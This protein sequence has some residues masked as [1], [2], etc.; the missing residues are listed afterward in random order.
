[1]FSLQET[2]LPRYACTSQNI[3]SRSNLLLG[4][5]ALPQTPTAPKL[6]PVYTQDGQLRLPAGSEI[7]MV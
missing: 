2:V 5:V 1:M 4:W 3:E 7:T 6:G